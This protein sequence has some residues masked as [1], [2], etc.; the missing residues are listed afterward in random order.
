MT[1]RNSFPD[2][3][4]ALNLDF[5][6][7][8]R[9][10]PRI[11]FTR[12]S[13]GTYVD[14]FGVIKT[15]A[16]NE[17]RFDHD[18]SGNSLG[19]LVEESR[20]NLFWYSEEFDN[21]WWTK[22]R[23][24]ITANSVVAPDGSTTA[25]TVTQ[26][27]TAGYH[28]VQ[29]T[30]LGLATST[31]YS[32]SVYVKAAGQTQIALTL[33]NSIVFGSPTILVTYNLSTVTATVTQANAAA[34]AVADIQSVGNGWYRL[35]VLGTTTSS[36]GNSVAEVWLLDNSGNL[37]FTGDGTSGIY[38]WGAQL[39]AG[40]FPTSYIPTSGSTAT[41]SADVAS[42]TGTNFSSWYNQSEGTLLT[43]IT[44]HDVTNNDFAYS[45]SDGTSSERIVSLIGS[46]Y[47]HYVV[48]GG[49]IQAQINYA[50]YTAN[51]ETK[52]A[53]AYATNDI[54]YATD[55]TVRGTDTSAT[56]PTV[57]N[58]VIMA[59]RSNGNHVTGTISRL[60]YYDRRLTDAQ[61]QALT[62]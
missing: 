3:R 23:V 12:S 7:T 47:S 5:A 51:T 42:M 43:N 30:T 32:Y 44:P 60:T 2:V 40:S 24:V 49:S 46:S 35:S 18:G 62:L 20:T 53:A 36:S 13:T 14:E 61:L 52:A 16:S 17:A 28:Y 58:L 4:P 6:N 57:D 37:S 54:A 1:I 59:N 19:L 25:D 56:I 34:N 26:D 33:G 31:R 55:G 11:T 41:R 9:L 39:E 22:S 15:A 21:A 27:T 50:G 48:D 10:D 29:R 45:L 8:K 38:I